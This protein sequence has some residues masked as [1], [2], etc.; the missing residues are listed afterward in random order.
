[1][2]ADQV[3]DFLFFVA[4]AD[5]AVSCIENIASEV[6]ALRGI[7]RSQWPKP[8]PTVA[9]NPHGTLDDVHVRVALAALDDADGQHE[10]FERGWVEWLE[11]C[12][13]PLLTPYDVR[14]K[15]AKA[16]RGDYANSK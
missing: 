9:D 11:R 10:K 15:I 3:N 7:D 12:D 13:Q 8:W 1:M 4:V 2:S 6:L 14:K 16:K 5:A